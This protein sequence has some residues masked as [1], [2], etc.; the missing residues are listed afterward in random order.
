MA[1]RKS[2]KN[3]TSE[4]IERFTLDGKEAAV[5]VVS[6]HD[7][8]TCDVVFDLR[9][10]KERFICRLLNYNAPELKEKP[11]GKL[12]RDY[13]AHLVTGGDPDADGFFDPE[14]IWRKEELQEELDKSKNLVYAV[15]EKFDSFGRRALVTLYT[16]SSKNK[17]INAMMTKFV[18]KL[19]KR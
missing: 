10:Q 6:V 8:D 11:N 4:D 7:G 13:L 9:G 1:T 17:S 18:Q 3:I 15:F 12:A 2:L 16:D 14:G 19:Y 5:K